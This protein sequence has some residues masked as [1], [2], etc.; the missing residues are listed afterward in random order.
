MS[1]LSLVF[2][3]LIYWL[4]K[5]IGGKWMGAAA[6]LFAAISPAQ[7][8]NSFSVWNA[9]ADPFLA[10]LAMIFLIRF[11]KE[12][13]A[14]DI[15]L[16][17]FIVSLAIT[18]HFQNALIGPLVLIAI[19]TSKPKIKNFAYMVIGLL[20]P[21]LP[22]L[23]FDLR[24]NW[25]ET[26]RI[27][28]YITIGQYRIW[29]P[30]RWLTYA[31]VYWPKTWAY[32]VG[33]NI[34]VGG[35]IITLLSLL[36]IF[37]LKDM[38]KYIL[39]YL[40]AIGFVLEVILFRYWRGERFAYFSHFAHPAV[41]LLTAWVAVELYRI[42]KIIGLIFV[43]LLIIFTF[44]E[45]LKNLKDRELTLPRVNLLKN[46]IYANYPQ[47]KFETYGCIYNGALISHPLS[48]V[49]YSEGRNEIGG[50]KIGVCQL[51]DKSFDW[52][53]LSGEDVKDENSA[54]FNETTSTVYKSMT[55]WWKENPPR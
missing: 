39:F 54:W 12:K 19:L 23:Y 11:Y 51:A 4:G 8:D 44:N 28:D 17:G 1:F 16:L 42:R 25:F 22:F 7:I 24:F 37:R 29:V 36:F 13:K 32:I 15:F 5:E 52:K 30:N 47:D 9:A 20:I 14:F 43:S 3:L 27:F 41:I 33:G 48:F 26:R 35:L 38:K 53:V 21:I 2:I 45:S 18:I 50:V 10:L 49:M 40:I 6:A 31:G 34:W 46:E 55:E